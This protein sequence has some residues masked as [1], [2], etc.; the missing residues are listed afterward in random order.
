MKRHRVPQAAVDG[1]PLTLPVTRRAEVFSGAIWDVVS[2]DVDLG[3]GGVVRREYVQHPGAV[4]VV[5]LDEEDRV[6]LLRQYR[7]P[8]R[9]Q[10]VEI[11]AG[12]LDV[13]GEDPLRAAQRELAEEAD[14]TADNWELLVDA[15]TSPGGSDER[16]KI[17]LAT[18]L[19]SVPQQQRHEREAEELAITVSRVPRTEAVAAV[20][21]GDI[22]NATAALGLL[23]LQARLA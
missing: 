1:P 9:R 4:A 7:H 10:L 12:L 5:A 22:A 16:I 20:L 8:A 18:G 2:D 17:Y 14:L 15:F 3:A 11:P 6:V 21:Q 13:P 19:R 23:V